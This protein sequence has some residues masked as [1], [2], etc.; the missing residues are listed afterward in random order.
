MKIRNYILLVMVALSIFSCTKDEDF[1]GSPYY[2]RDTLYIDK[3]TIGEAHNGSSNSHGLDF[4]NQDYGNGGVEVDPDEVDDLAKILGKEWVL[5]RAVA[6]VENRDLYTKKYYNYFSNTRNTASMSLF[7]PTEVPIFDEITLHE[8]TWNFEDGNYFTI[9]GEH[10][11]YMQTHYNALGQL[12]FRPYGFNGGTARPIVVQYATNEMMK[13][14][15]RESFNGDNTYNYDYFSELT[16]KKVGTGYGHDGEIIEGYT[17]DGLWEYNYQETS[18][19]TV[20]SMVGSEWVI[21]RYDRGI[22]PYYPNDTLR[23]TSVN[24]YTINS[25]PVKRRYT[26]YNVTNTN[27][28]SI[29]LYG[30]TTLG[31]DYSGEVSTQGLYDGFINNIM[32]NDIWDDQNQTNVWMRRI[33]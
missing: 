7:D 31:G 20:F 10:T 33:N 32:F 1:F 11:Y 5:T 12:I 19:N 8:T 25:N 15:T 28:T 29:T 2:Y 18:D 22:Q 27:M 13:V 3:D 24:E 16:F 14:I 23:F 6:Y 30:L 9:D 26:Y 17:F 4:V 21:T